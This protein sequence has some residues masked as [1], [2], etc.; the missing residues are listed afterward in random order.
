MAL[1]IGLCKSQ[2]DAALVALMRQ[3][4]P[5]WLLQLPWFVTADDRQQ[6]QQEVTGAT[7][8]RMLREFGELLDRI[9]AMRPLVVIIEDLHWSDAATLQLLGYLVRRPGSARVLQV[10]ARHHRRRRRGGS[11]RKTARWP[12]LCR[13]EPPPSPR[14]RSARAAR[15]PARRQRSPSLR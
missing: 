14:L 15:A 4:A 12:P 8:E 6:L 9:S 1:K 7:R 3:V 13:G 2:P 5:T 10:R 11:Q